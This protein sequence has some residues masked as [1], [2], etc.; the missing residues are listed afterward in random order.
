MSLELENTDGNDRSRTM[1]ML[2]G[3]YLFLLL[4]TLTSYGQSV[5]LF[6]TIVKNRWAEI[7][8]ITDSL[9]CLH[10]FIGLWKRQLLTWYLIIAYN[11]FEASNTIVNLFRLP[12]NEIEQIVGKPVDKTSLIIT[13][14]VT[15]ILISWV[16]VTVFRLKHLF[17]N[18]SP[19]L[20]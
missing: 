20:F 12:I 16:S 5:P 10:I 8:I 9:I 18:R 2:T 17:Q 3:L 14:L 6:G 7:F 1:V 15:V 13:N 19:Y 11:F 4:M